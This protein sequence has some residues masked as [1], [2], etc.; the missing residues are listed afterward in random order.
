MDVKSTKYKESNENGWYLL[1]VNKDTKEVVKNFDYKEIKKIKM[2][3]ITTTALYHLKNDGLFYKAD[4]ETLLKYEITLLYYSKKKLSSR[5][6]MKY[7]KQI[8]AIDGYYDG[9]EY[10]IK[11]NGEFVPF[12]K[13]YKSWRAYNLPLVVSLIQIL[14]IALTYYY[15]IEIATWI[16]EK[17]FKDYDKESFAK[18][19]SLTNT[20]LAFLMFY[21]ALIYSTFTILVKDLIKPHYLKD[22][23]R[24][25]RNS[26]IVFEIP[27]YI[28]AVYSVLK[29][30]QFEGEINWGIFTSIAVISLL[31]ISGKILF[32]YFLEK[33][34]RQK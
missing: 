29:I 13:N 16:K 17:I 7:K 5:Y 20:L 28:A 27:V 30:S 12:D 1:V 2:E 34:K 8:N 18:F 32:T 10:N 31:L 14:F 22:D 19:Y 23:L 15:S 33:E 11:N 21:I 24:R 4:I 9:W 3:N 6:V 26:T 25:I